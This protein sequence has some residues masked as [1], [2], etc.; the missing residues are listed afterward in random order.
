[1]PYWKQLANHCL[2]Q[3]DAPRLGK[4]GHR[5]DKVVQSGKQS[6]STMLQILSIL[7]GLII[8][9][10]FNQKGKAYFELP[11]LMSSSSRRFDLH[12]LEDEE[13]SRA[14][15]N[16]GHFFGRASPDQDVVMHG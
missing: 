7:S 13:I 3:S 9:E 15:I 16:L 1:L 8:E 2:L 11:T 10:I 6:T 12:W 14:E 4:S 5:N